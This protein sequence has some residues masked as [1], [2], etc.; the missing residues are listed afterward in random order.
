ML[1]YQ[2]CREF[3]LDLPDKY[4]MA[5][6]RHYVCR[7]L[8]ILWILTRLIH[9]WLTPRVRDPETVSDHPAA[10]RLNGNP[11]AVK[12]EMVSVGPKSLYFSR[13]SVRILNRN[14]SGAVFF[15]GLPRFRDDSLPTAVSLIAAEKSLHL[16]G[17]E[18]QEF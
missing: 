8:Q 18:A 14:S 12:S 3:M 7:M 9:P 15:A 1:E 4:I 11:Y 2:R 13:S 5:F 6:F 17:A 16:T 10:Q